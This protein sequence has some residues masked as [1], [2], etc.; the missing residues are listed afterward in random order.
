MGSPARAALLAAGAELAWTF[1]TGSHFEAMTHYHM[2]AHGEAYT[3][4]QAQ[5]FEPYPQEWANAQKAG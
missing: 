1:Q 2:R 4:D 5:A 3:S